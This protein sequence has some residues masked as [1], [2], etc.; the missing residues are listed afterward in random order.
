M[1]T[2]NN[3]NLLVVSKF[4][5]TSMGDASCMLRSADV[6]L[7]QNAKIV[8][9]SATSGTTND[10]IDL[11]KTSQKGTWENTLTILQKIKTRHEQIAKELELPENLNKKMS[12]HFSE[13]ESMARGIHLLKDCSEKAMDTILSFGERLSSLLF[14]RAM[15][16]VLQKNNYSTK[17]LWLDVREILITDDQFSKARPLVEEIKKKCE[18]QL[19]GLRHQNVVY[20]T[21]GFIGSTKEGQTTT[22]GRGGSDYSAALI[23]EGT[24]A[25]ILEIWTDVAGIATTDPRICPSARVIPEISFKEASELATFGAKILHPA[26]LMPAMRSQIPV[27][28]G[29]SFAPLQGGTWIKK[30]VEEAPLIRAMAIRKNQVLVTLST[31]EML[32]THGF[33]YQIFKIFNDHK[34]SVDAIT[35]S[36][37]SVSMTLDESALLNKELIE[38]LETLAVVTIEENLSLISLIGNN[39]NHT[40]GLAKKIFNAIDGINVRMI[41]LG[42]SKHNF[43][44]IID[45]NEGHNALS[46]LHQTFIG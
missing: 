33:L 4:G 31:P 3:Q 46:K 42:A 28:V 19:S 10:L 21:Q 29:S 39:I 9:V 12:E 2:Q 36:E 15:E 44:F 25:D 1:S 17:S 16:I 37:I 18:S 34:V 38:D 23:A 20:V 27:F 22:L 8:V 14:T 13:L 40:P 5:G 32:Y 43:C 45:G 6:S 35:T 41:C 11:S 26:T 30:E 24:G 7:S